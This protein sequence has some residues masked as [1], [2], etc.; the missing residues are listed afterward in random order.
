L[1]RDLSSGYTPLKGDRK[2][3]VAVLGAGGI[4][5]DIGEYWGDIGDELQNGIP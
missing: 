2:K 1:T 4:I 3:R 5:G